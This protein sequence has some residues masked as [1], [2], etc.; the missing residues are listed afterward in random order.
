VDW[1]ALGVLIFEMLSGLPPYHQPEANQVALYEKIT[2][3]PTS[4]RWPAAFSPLA[5]DLILK[6]M[7]GDPSK[8]YGNLRHGAGDVFAHGW[9]REVD[10]ERLA[11]RDIQAP[12]LP[13]ING[14]GD[15]SA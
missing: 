11:A 9:F 3:G 7:E 13:K 2:K 4:I 15:A 5:T 1:Y 12:Y 6:L 10:W 14:D 8:R